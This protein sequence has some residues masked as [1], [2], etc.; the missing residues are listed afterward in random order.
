MNSASEDEDDEDKLDLDA[1]DDS[2][3]GAEADEEKETDN[4]EDMISK[5]F[6]VL[7]GVDSKQQIASEDLSATG[8][9]HFPLHSGL[10]TD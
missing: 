5:T 7:T 1:K 4:D 9:L 8:L 2:E 6:T 10:F 3:D